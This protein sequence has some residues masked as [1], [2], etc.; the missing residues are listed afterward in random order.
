[1]NSLAY[2]Y[3]E[4]LAAARWQRDVAGLS[5]DDIRAQR[6]SFYEQPDEFN[7]EQLARHRRLKSLQT[8]AISKREGVSR[9]GQPYTAQT[10]DGRV[11]VTPDAAQSFRAQATGRISDAFVTHP[12]DQ[13][14]DNAIVHHELGERAHYNAARANEIGAR[15]V[16]SHF[17]EVPNIA[18]RLQTFRDP[19]ANAI[20][21]NIRAQDPGDSFIQNKMKQFGHT[22][23]APMPLGGRA[24]RALA[25]EVLHN[26]PLNTDSLQSRMLGTMSHAV[27]PDHVPHAIRAPIRLANKM[28]EQARP[29]LKNFSTVRR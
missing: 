6:A 13:V 3:G 7:T 16:A 2:N 24:H 21:N 20:F 1:M 12:V 5:P 4:K 15:S 14:V 10:I 11:N 26:A 18:E 29:Y 23:N 17:G 19:D 28:Y 22:P 25:R 8:E 27:T 9:T